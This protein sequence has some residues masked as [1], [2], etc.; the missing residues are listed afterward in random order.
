MADRAL[1][2]R[3]VLRAGA[4]AGLAGDAATLDPLRFDTAATAG[5]ETRAVSGRFEVGAPDWVYLPVDVP[6]GVREITVTYTFDRPEPV[7]GQPGNGLDIGIFDESGH[8]LG[9]RRGFRGWSGGARDS[10]SMTASEAT[11]GYLPGPVRAGR[12]HVILGPYTVHPEGM[13]WTVEVTLRFGAPGPRFTP[14]PA[15]Q[16]ATGRGRDWYRGDMHL[17]TVHSDGQWLPEQAVAGARA[18]GLDFIT[19]TEHNTTSASGIWG[20]H[21]TDDLL[22]IDGEEITT[23]NGHFVAAGLRPGTWIDWRYRARDHVIDR[24]VRQV[25]RDEGIAIAA[26]PFCP[27]L[28][29]RWKFGYERFDAV[30]V[31]NG[32][33]TPEDEVALQ[34]W[35]ALLVEHGR[36]RGGWLPAVGNSDSH[37]EGQVIG[38]PQTVVLADDLTR[39]AVLDGVRAGRVY[40]AESAAVSL[41]LEASSN[42]RTA[43]IGERLDAGAGDPVDVTLTVGGAP[44][45]T[46]VFHTDQGQAAERPLPA[47]GRVT[48]ATR[49]RVSTY[50]RAEVRRAPVV[51]GLPGPLVAFTNPIFLGDD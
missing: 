34:Q 33:W 26:H 31:W 42:G 48:W 44:G 18:A 35:D 32:P 11:P 47:D 39:A 28:G 5:E 24:F 25:H 3:D 49:P 14:S 19:S 4:A 51:P 6:A 45:A 50:V 17:H 38:L 13:D 37:R 22:V 2:R 12:W 23:R 9:N 20:H 16:R 15:P 36:R 27:V 21:A 43:G 46:A 7:P 10:F 29:C 41:E 1:S 30:E 40:V 8:E